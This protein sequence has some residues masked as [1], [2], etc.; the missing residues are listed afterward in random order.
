MP[1]RNE[2]A[3][4]AGVSGIRALLIAEWDHS[5]KRWRI[6]GRVYAYEEALK[7]GGPVVIS[8]N[9]LLKA[10]TLAVCQPIGSASAASTARSGFCWKATS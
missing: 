8:A 2:R 5:M 1:R 10:F 4:I 7:G 6:P 3:D 9:R